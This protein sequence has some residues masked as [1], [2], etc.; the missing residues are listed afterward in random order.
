MLIPSVDASAPIVPKPS[1][2]LMRLYSSKSPQSFIPDV[3][4]LTPLGEA[5]VPFIS[6]KNTDEFRK[7]KYKCVCQRFILKSIDVCI[8]QYDLIGDSSVSFCSTSRRF[9]TTT[10]SL[11]AR[12]PWKSRKR[13]ITSSAS[14]PTTGILIFCRL[15]SRCSCRL[16][17]VRQR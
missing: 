13:G 2:F 14:L 6:F 9:P 4:V 16:D 17:A 5:E 8:S 10:L 12:A 3:S 7:V 15:H 1:K 11:L